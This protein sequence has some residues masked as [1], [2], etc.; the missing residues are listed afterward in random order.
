MEAQA[1]LILTSAPARRRPRARL[2]VNRLWPLEVTPTSVDMKDSFMLIVL[3]A[4]VFVF[5]YLDEPMNC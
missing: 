3:L 2:I 1:Q 5:S 4:M